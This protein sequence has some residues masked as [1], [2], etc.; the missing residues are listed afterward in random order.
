MCFEG[1]KCFFWLVYKIGIYSFSDV[2]IIKLSHECRLASKLGTE[3]NCSDNEKCVLKGKNAFLWL[4]YK[5]ESAPFLIYTFIKLSR[6]CR[7]A[8]KLGT[9]MT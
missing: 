2:Y 6:E 4:V 3:K 7:P 1:K 8:S 5:L 9:E